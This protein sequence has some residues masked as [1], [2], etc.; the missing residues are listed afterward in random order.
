[1]SGILAMT[2]HHGDL[3]NGQKLAKTI[4]GTLCLEVESSSRLVCIVHYG[5]LSAL[6]F[7]TDS[8]GGVNQMKAIIYN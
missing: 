4:K 3:Y 7:H 5:L 2:W 1:M 8:D 6:G